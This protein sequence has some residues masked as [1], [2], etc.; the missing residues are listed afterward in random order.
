MVKWALERYLGVV[1]A[2][3]EPI[4]MTDEEL[5]EYTG[6][7]RSIS[8]IIRVTVEEGRLMVK[9]EP[10]PEALARL[11][12]RDREEPEEQPPIPLAL[13][14]DDRYTAAGGPA[15][16]MR[17]YFVRD[18]AGAVSGIHLGGRLATRKTEETTG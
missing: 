7:Y 16:G 14:A 11:R 8:S 3:P 2:E 6:E 9:I 15:K 12:E 17:G 18:E 1:E 4:V 13:H 10:T 5:A